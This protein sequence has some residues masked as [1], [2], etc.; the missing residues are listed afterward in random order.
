MTNSLEM[1]CRELVEL[2]TEY[3][4][5]TLEPEERT[6]LEAHLDECEGC[7]NY[8][9]E[10]RSTVRLVGRLTEEAVP[11][12]A[13]DELMGVFRRWKAGESRQR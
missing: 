13:L 12:A 11:A 2:V 5:G 7:V 4:E 9:N 8:L 3:L 6:R 1:W 10:M